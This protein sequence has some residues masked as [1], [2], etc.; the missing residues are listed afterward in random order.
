MEE[1]DDNFLDGVIEFGDGRQYK[2]NSSELERPDSSDTQGVPSQGDDKPD[3]TNPVTKEERFV[4][5][6]D[7][8]WPRSK[9]SPSSS[10]KEFPSNNPRSASPKPLPGHSPRENP[11]VLFN[12]RSNRLEPYNHSHRQAQV[13]G[14]FGQK[15]PSVNEGNASDNLR[16]TREGS[17]NVQV[18]RKGT[19]GDY[20]RSRRFSS[21]STGYTPGPNGYAGPHREGR[22]EPP[23]SSPRLSRDQPFPSS[24]GTFNDR[25]RRTSMGPPPLPASTS[26]RGH[27]RQLPPHLSPETIPRR[28]SSR[29]SQLLS[30]LDAPRS[31]S[32]TAALSGSPA[33][34]HA[35]LSP[36]KTPYASL[37]GTAMDLEEI[38]K[39]VMHNAA[40]RA[41]ARR[42]IEEEE[43]E[44]QKERAR[45]KAAELEERIKTEKSD[46][47]ENEEVSNVPSVRKF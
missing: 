33:M 29:D 37:P 21:S 11:R 43:R 16:G 35:S 26:Q 25:T 32:L 20:P 30:P 10:A 40:E 13:Q 23:P 2:V 41:K 44:A 18:L 22:R 6:F 24:E 17:H 12:E 31:P 8:S 15:R 36:H 38:R 9:G 28:L 19:S 4:D 45:R 39:D 42:Q 3:P 7:R 14:P 1:D 5:D 27:N 46:Q 34:S 47:N